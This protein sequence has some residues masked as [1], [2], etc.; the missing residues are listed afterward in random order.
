MLTYYF[1]T[2]F[3]G[4]TKILKVFFNLYSV[5]AVKIL[6]LLLEIKLSLPKWRTKPLYNCKEFSFMLE[7]EW[8]FYF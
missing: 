5:H 3:R 4:F 6:N 2:K 1:T 7:E 8:Y